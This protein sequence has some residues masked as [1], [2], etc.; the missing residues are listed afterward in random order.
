MEVLCRVLTPTEIRKE[1]TKP[2][3]WEP[4][5]K[6]NTAK[7]FL[8]VSYI[9]SGPS[10]FLVYDLSSMEMATNIRDKGILSLMGSESEYT[11]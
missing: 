2:E 9:A 8:L 5:F 3:L 7:A 4:F 10:D 11:I 1:Y 6:E